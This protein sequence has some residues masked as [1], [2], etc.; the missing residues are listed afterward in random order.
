MVVNIMG[1]HIQHDDEVQLGSLLDEGGAISLLVDDD[2]IS[3]L[4]DYD[5]IS[6]WHSEVNT[7]SKVIINRD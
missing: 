6:K 5:A 7:N 3:S 4:D 2:A 1:K